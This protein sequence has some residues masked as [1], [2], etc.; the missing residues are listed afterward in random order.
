MKLKKEKESKKSSD[1][2]VRLCG[3]SPR[4]SKR[5]II[6]ITIKRERE[7]EGER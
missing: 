7:G 3:A 2:E 6:I 1:S 4:T 5:A